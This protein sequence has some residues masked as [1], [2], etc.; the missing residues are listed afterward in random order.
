[1]RFDWREQGDTSCGR[2][3]RSVAQRTGLSG[4]LY[5]CI[6]AQLAPTRAEGCICR[7]GWP[8]ATRILLL[9]EDGMEVL[10]KQVGVRRAVLAVSTH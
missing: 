10:E 4:S 6:M 1:M 2:C 8:L 5:R 7:S 9:L 3:V